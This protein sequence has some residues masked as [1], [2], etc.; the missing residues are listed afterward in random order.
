[1]QFIGLAALMS[2]IGG[3]AVEI[4]KFITSR[5]GYRS[6]ALVAF[7]SAVGLVINE[8]VTWISQ[9]AGEVLSQVPDVSAV[10][11]SPFIPSL[12]PY[13]FSIVIATKI[14]VTGFL[15]VKWFISTK[16]EYVGKA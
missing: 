16:F 7:I 3:L 6:V 12:L 8:F 4:V 15:F 11:Y 10:L 2:F 1:M 14:T 5:I 9:K 13:C